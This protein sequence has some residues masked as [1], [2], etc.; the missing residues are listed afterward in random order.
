MRIMIDNPFKSPETTDDS[1][2]RHPTTSE[3]LLA[4][5]WRP[6]FGLGVLLFLLIAGLAAVI[7]L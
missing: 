2:P 1:P 4:G 7:L 6:G 3:P 5:G